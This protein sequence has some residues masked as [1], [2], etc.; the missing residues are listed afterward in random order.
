MSHR[1][2][3]TNWQHVPW[4]GQHCFK[5][6]TLFLTLIHHFSF[7]M[8]WCN[9]QRSTLWQALL[10]LLLELHAFFFISHSTPHKAGIWN[11]QGHQ[12][13]YRLLSKWVNF[14]Q[15]HHSLEILRLS[16]LPDCTN[17]IQKVK[18]TS[19]YHCRMQSQLSSTK[20]AYF[21]GHALHKGTYHITKYSHQWEILP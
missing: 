7:H 14:S 9:S 20:H 13:I 1:P 4:F 21:V 12:L 16:A 15:Q 11:I 17:E 19:R 18:A 8:E 10:P 5:P 3:N 2:H 6:F